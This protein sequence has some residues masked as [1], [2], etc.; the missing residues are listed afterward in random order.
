MLETY[1]EYE[2]WFDRHPR[3]ILYKK[4]PIESPGT[5]RPV[6]INQQAGDAGLAVSI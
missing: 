3:A 5:R 2:H 4:T 6:I 1:L